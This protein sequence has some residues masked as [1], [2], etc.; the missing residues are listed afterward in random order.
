MTAKRRCCCSEAPC[1]GTCAFA[2]SYS[3]TGISGSFSHVRYTVQ[4]DCGNACQFRDW[5]LSLSWVQVGALVVTK[6]TAPGGGTPCCYHGEGTVTV[7]GTLTIT[8]TYEDGICPDSTQTYTY[9]F[10]R[11]VPCAVEVTCGGGA[12]CSYTPQSEGWRHTLH[13]CDFLVTCSHGWDQG[14]CDTCPQ[15]MGPY[16]LRC[17]GGTVAYTSELVAL[18]AIDRTGCLGWY[19][20]GCCNAC[21]FPAMATNRQFGPFAIALS[22]ECSEQDEYESCSLGVV[23]NAFL[24][25]RIDA[26]PLT[27]PWLAQ[28]DVDSKSN[29]GSVDFSGGPS[30]TCVTD[31]IQGGCST[32]P[33]DYA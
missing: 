3:V 11:D 25:T 1:S 6:Q 12:G 28:A 18:D 29:C 26:D 4:R 2:S 14:D 16:A 8:D 15:P 13:I 23:T 32:M 20:A 21:P 33:W 30:P 7:T 17:I 31:I 22:E 5:S 9:A 10:E 27:S 24:S 19:A